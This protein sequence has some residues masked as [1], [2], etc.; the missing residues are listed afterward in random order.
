VVISSNRGM[1]ISLFD[2]CHVSVRHKI[3]KDE[4]KTE[5]ECECEWIFR[6]ENETPDLPAVLRTIQT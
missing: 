5:E 2:R 3:V 1:Q 4:A 6:G